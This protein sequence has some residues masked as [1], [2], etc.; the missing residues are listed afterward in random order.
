MRYQC[1]NLMNKANDDYV[2]YTGIVNRECKR[3]KLNELTAG[4]F[5][6]LIFVQGLKAERDSEIRFHILSKVEADSKQTL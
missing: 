5:R 4:N 3:F 2:T 6:C 1:L